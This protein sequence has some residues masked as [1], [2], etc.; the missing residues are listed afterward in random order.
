[1]LGRLTRWLR[2]ADDAGINVPPMDGVLKPNNRLE[3]AERVLALPAIDNLSAG[4][5]MVFASSGTKLYGLQRDGDGL[6]AERLESFPAPITF[7]AADATGNFAIGIEGEGVRFGAP[8]KG[9]RSV[10]LAA[11][12]AK[13]M[14][15]ASFA[16]DGKLLVCIGSRAFAASDW[17]RDLMHRGRSG[18]ILAVSENG[19]IDVL[20]DGMAFPFGVAALDERR[21]VFSESWQHRLAACGLAGR[22]APQPLLA[23][24]PAYPARIS[25]ASGGGF[26]L[27]LFAPRRQLFEMVLREHDYRH[28]MMATIDPA[29]WIGPDLASDDGPEQPLQAGAVRQMGLIKPWAPSRSYGLVIRC[30]R[31][32]HPVESWHSRADGTMHGVTSVIEHEG[33]VLAASRGSGTLLRLSGAENGS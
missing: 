28:A 21:F 22:E 14:T 10:P 7:I 16:P 23:D 33:H 9:W 4:M 2:P 1:M 12:R 30:D 20:L 24:L 31:E 18:L 32:C 6:R 3:E 26:W 29:D 5:E 17:K 11:D 19:A 13:C 27:S 25:P 8:G 15:A